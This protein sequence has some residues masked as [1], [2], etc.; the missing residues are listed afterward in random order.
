M[1]RDNQG[2]ESGQA[3]R[4][5]QIRDNARQGS[6]PPRE[7]PPARPKKAGKRETAPPAPL[8]SSRG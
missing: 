3:C 1:W 5:R 2:E 4:W 8:T 7:P 6:K